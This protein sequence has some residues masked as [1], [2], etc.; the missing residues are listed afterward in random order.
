MAVS[1]KRKSMK[2]INKNKLSKKSKKSKTK[3]RL[4]NKQIGGFDV[5][6][7]DYKKCNGID[8]CYIQIKRFYYLDYVYDGKNIIEQLQSNGNMLGKNVDNNSIYYLGMLGKSILF[9]KGK[10]LTSLYVTENTHPNEHVNP[11]RGITNTYLV[12]PDLVTDLVNNKFLP[13]EYAPPGYSPPPPLPKPDPEPILESESESEPVPEPEHVPEPK[14]EPV[15]VPVP[16]IN[17]NSKKNTKPGFWK[18]LFRSKKN[19]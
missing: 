9:T 11:K 19:I 6:E 3:N 13:I 4:Q 7:Y 18:R 10:N 8:N 12:N 14:P 15:P 5:K 2:K 1:N 16:V 17:K